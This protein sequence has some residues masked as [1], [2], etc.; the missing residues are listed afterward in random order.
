MNVYPLEVEQVLEEHPDVVE[1]AVYGVP[2]DDWGT[3]VCAAVVGEADEAAL[4][5]WARER[6]APPKRPKTWTFVA[7]LPRTATGKVRRDRL[8][9]PRDS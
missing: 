1:V 5:A 8:G 7:D 9:A 6:L 3:R 4:A 2:D